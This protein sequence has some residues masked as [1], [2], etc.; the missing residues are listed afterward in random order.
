[1]G[2][3]QLLTERMLAFEPAPEEGPNV[4]RNR[5]PLWQPIWAR[6]LYGGAVI[7]QSLAVVQAAVPKGFIVHSMHCHFIRPAVNAKPIFYHVNKVREGKSVGVW[8]VDARQSG[9]VVFSATVSFARN[10]AATKAK[11]QLQHQSAPP[12]DV[13]AEGPPTEPEGPTDDKQTSATSQTDSGSLM[14]SVRLP[15]KDYEAS[16]ATTRLF[17]WSRIRTVQDDSSNNNTSPSDGGVVAHLAALAY[18]SDAYF[19]GTTSRV[20]RAERFLGGSSVEEIKRSV[21]A[22]TPLGK[23]TLLAFQKLAEEERE[24]NAHGSSPGTVGMMVTLSHS[25]FFHNATEVRADEWLLVEAESPW[26]GEERGLVLQ[27]VWTASG[28]LIATCIQEGVVRLQQDET[29]FKSKF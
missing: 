22:S 3:R 15:R 14:E 12:S 24:D 21:D 20:H 9:N 23:Q 8:S 6:G 17:Q 2:R 10:T 27:R 29:Q 4:Y 1:M 26:A 11:K 19:I 5:L 16:P 7:A 18:I 13:W 28:V 25:I